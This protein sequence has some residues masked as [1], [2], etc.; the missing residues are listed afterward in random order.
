MCSSDLDEIEHFRV[1][2]ISL[3][4][5]DVSGIAQPS[6]RSDCDLGLILHCQSREGGVTQFWD[7]GQPNNPIVIQKGLRLRRRL[8]I[9]LALEGGGT[10]ART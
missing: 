3:T 9:R 7:K 4:K 2:E 5:E 8:R 1:Q 6:G 10:G